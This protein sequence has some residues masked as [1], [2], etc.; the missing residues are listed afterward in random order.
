MIR[1]WVGCAANNEDLE[2]Q[3]VLEWSLRKH[4]ARELEI[5][6]MQ[7]SRDP[8]SPFYSDGPRGWQTRFWTTPFSGLRWAVPELCG[9]HCEAIYTDSDV[10][11]L[12]DIG[13]L[14]DQPFAADTVVIGKG[15]GQS[16]RLCVSKWNCERSR[17]LLPALSQLQD[18]P[19]S[20]R[21][22]LE[23]FSRL[24]RAVQQFAGGDWNRLDLEPFD[25]ADPRVKALHYTGI[26]TQVQLKH[27]LPRLAR[28][29][30]RHWFPG[31]AKPHRSPQLQALFDQLLQEATA[32]GF[33]IE[34]Y[35]REP[36]GRYEIR[37]GR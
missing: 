5:R 37:S 3:A 2:S 1:I 24:T 11:F 13:E 22:L 31:P 21:V 25:L 8:A 14:W 15:G 10:I 16:Q 34:R 7:L 12:A 36:F 27:A 9:W 17:A 20:H 33:G 35:R 18:D 32:N 30:G 19:R 26:P 28:E 23:R 4:T 6:W 29:G